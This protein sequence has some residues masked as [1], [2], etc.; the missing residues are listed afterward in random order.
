MPRC[1]ELAKLVE[2]PTKNT[3]TTTTTTGTQPPRVE[4]GGS[5]SMFTGKR[6]LALGVAGVGVVA[7]GAA[8]VLGTQ[9]KGFQSD[10]YAL[11]PN[12]AM[13]CPRADEANSL[14]EKGRGR[15]LGANI[16]YGVGGAAVIG[17]A[18]LWFTGAPSA[19]EGR[20]AVTPRANGID[21]AVRF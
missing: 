12:P 3:T 6:K 2:P 7:I 11:C 15:A 20:V 18:I 9:A 16:A 10:A 1:K 13:A 5:P 19:N 17:A 8:L 4:G 21:L 14:M